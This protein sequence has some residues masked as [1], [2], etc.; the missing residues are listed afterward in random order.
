MSNQA[1]LNAVDEL[2][3]SAIHGRWDYDRLSIIRDALTEQSSSISDSIPMDKQDTM[4]D[5]NPLARRM[6]KCSHFKDSPTTCYHKDE[7]CPR[8][9][10]E[11]RETAVI[12]EPAEV[13][14]E[15]NARIALAVARQ[16]GERKGYTE[17]WI[18]KDATARLLAAQKAISQGEKL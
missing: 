12:P 1:A 11:T 16:Y 4:A 17:E 5:H 15:R 10:R 8:S 7:D 3:V 9:C 14:A 13:W 2:W 18:A 6:V